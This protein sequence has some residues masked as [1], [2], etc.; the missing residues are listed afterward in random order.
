V[1]KVTRKGVLAL[2]KFTHSPRNENHL[3]RFEDIITTS[4]FL[5]QLALALAFGAATILP[6]ALSAPVRVILFFGFPT[7]IN[8]LL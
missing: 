2:G 4:S 5:S 6:T 1:A 8:A 3:T 7:V